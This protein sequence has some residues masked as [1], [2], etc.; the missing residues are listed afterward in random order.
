MPENRKE[1]K[2]CHDCGLE[3]L[4]DCENRDK[5]IPIDENSPP[6]K[7][8]SR[9]QIL[10]ELQSNVATDFFSEAW[11]LSEGADG[12]WSPLI[13][14][15]NPLERVLLRRLHTLMNAQVAR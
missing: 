10:H 1:P 6:C 14:D 8:C 2:S 4:G 11:T 12:H 3:N 13:E 7:F 9:N 5:H 15:A